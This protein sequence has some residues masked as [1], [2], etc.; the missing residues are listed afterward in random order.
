MV[1]VDAVAQPPITGPA[2]LASVPG[3]PRIGKHREVKK[4]LEAFWSG[5]IT[6]EELI[7][8]A[9]AVR[10]AGWDSQSSAGLDLL[11][12]NDFSFYD[13]ILD[14]IGLFGAIPA[15]YGW[16]G[17]EPD[18]DT[19]FAMARGRTGEHD[20]P[21]MEMT[22]W[23][24]TN[25]HNI[26]PELGPETVFRVAGGKPTYMLKAAQERGLRAKVILVGPV[27]F[28]ALAKPT[29]EGFNPLSLL[30]QLLPAYLEVVKDLA[31]NGA[32]WIQIDEPI[33]VT[34]FPDGTLA[35]LEKAYAAIATVKGN[36][37][38]IVQTYFDHVGT[39]GTYKTLVNLP[40]DGIGLDLVRGRK[41]LDLIAEHGFPKD[42]VLVAGVVDGRN[43]WINDLA[44]SFA[45]LTALADRIGAGNIHVST[46]CSLQH[47]PYDVTRETGIDPEVRSWL[48]FAEQKLAEVVLLAKGLREGRDAIAAELDARTALLEAASQ[49]PKRRNPAVQDR[50]ATLPADAVDRALPY[51]QRAAIQQEKLHLPLLPTTTIGSFPQTPELRVVRRK[52]DKG[53]ITQA[54]Y[55]TFLEG[56]IKDV[57]AHQEELGIDVL[58]HGEPERNDMVQYFGEQLDGFAFTQQ[59]WVQS[60]G[61]RYVRPPVI[62]GDVSRPKPMTVRWATFAQSLSDKPVKGMLTGPVTI[63]NWSFVRD[64]QPRE[65]TCKQIALA[66]RDEVSDLEQAGIA[67]IQIDE[68]ALREGLPL[69][70]ADWQHY[71]DWA[72]ASFRITA[73][74]AAPETQVHTHMCYS[75][76]GDI[77]QAI[78]DLD[79]DV[80]S[81]EN[82]RSGLDLLQSF[83]E[84]G[85]DKGVG[86]GVYDIHSPRVPPVDEIARN[87]EATL[88]VLDR[89]RVWINPDCGLKTRKAPETEAA[90]RNMV[91]AAKQV[92][93]TLGEPVPTA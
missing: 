1:D 83:R 82:A 5:K 18:M 69:H 22:K 13:Q 19:Y 2:P 3:Y 48:A 56:Q 23:F 54:E 89:E 27:T 65:V 35:A 42:K 51:A 74:G 37:K 85:Y 11:P 12:V 66:I 92:R 73:A 58:V 59:G 79:A 63:L 71:L 46:S 49:S 90:L 88:S 26:V 24:D 14:T 7:D 39:A 40:V 80:I 32:E 45:T 20:V 84:Q 50:L 78:S 25:Y 36:A 93:A 47:V 30:D 60:Y 77:F 70:R 10:D 64:D 33:L 43:I 16:D 67:I 41:N 86:P 53:E 81:I 57:I 4:A 28:L 91:D 62:F 17:S 8:T 44:A 72:V 29:V 52:A 34:D 21:A 31:D 55:E 68:A 76:F 61:S 6:A 87:L 38:V 15:R 75:E 9:D